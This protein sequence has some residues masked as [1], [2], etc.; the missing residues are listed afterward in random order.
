[1][2]PAER[3][4]LLMLARIQLHKVDCLI[5]DHRTALL[6]LQVEEGGVGSSL[7]QTYC[8]AIEFLEE[9]GSLLAQ[10][11]KKVEEQ[12]IEAILETGE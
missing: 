6:D 8:S 12:W 7:Q 3:E 5:G 1:M 10:L 4:L 11:V 9:Q 2:T